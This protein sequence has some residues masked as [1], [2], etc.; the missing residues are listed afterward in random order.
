MI[1]PN[2]SV[3][4]FTRYRMEKR[5]RDDTEESGEGV[6]KQSRVDSHDTLADRVA[7]MKE[8][9]TCRLNHFLG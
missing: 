3:P 6:N 7:L 5:P 9:L 8:V 1:T 2:V 4:N